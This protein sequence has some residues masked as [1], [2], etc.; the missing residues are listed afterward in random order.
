MGA[1]SKIEWTD[2]TWIVDRGGRRVRTYRKQDASR[3]GQQERRTHAALG[4]RWCRECR[5]WLPSDEVT[6]VGL[7]RPHAAAEY[8]R[9]YAANPDPIRQRVSARKRSIA[10]LPKVAMQMLTETFGGRCAYC[11]A[12]AATWDHVEPVV[13][14][15]DTT[16]GN[17]V[18]ACVSCNSSKKATDVAEW[19]ERTG[20][21]PHHALFDVLALVA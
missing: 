2:A 13:D 1:S 19:L 8:R 4:E 7:C 16:P 18:P 6:R 12:P 14:G 20:R 5:G 9:N 10:P 3:P 21:E 11:P 17:V 15:G